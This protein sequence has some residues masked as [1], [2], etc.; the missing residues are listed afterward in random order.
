MNKSLTQPRTRKMKETLW[1]KIIKDWE[2]SG[3]RQQ[4]Y[5]RSKKI[6]Y[7]TFTYWR[8]RLKNTS[9]SETTSLQTS[10]QFVPITVLSDYQSELSEELS[11]HLRNG[12]WIKIRKGFDEQTLHQVLR[13]ADV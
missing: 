9:K 11:L 6:N 12:R 2:S 4:A 8:G 10:K 5:C 3:S 1:D 7:N 13:C